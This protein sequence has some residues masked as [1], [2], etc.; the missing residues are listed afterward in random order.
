MHE[1]AGR[2]LG[3]GGVPRPDHDAAHALVRHQDVRAAAQHRDRQHESPRHREQTNQIAF[4]PRVHQPV[5][6]PA[7]A[8]RGVMG[9]GNVTMD[10][11]SP[12]NG[13]KRR[14][15]LRRTR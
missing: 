3:D 11:V 7:D 14:L 15:H 6:V 8:K 10:T 9:D 1:P 13:G 12:D 4:P 5:R 2:H